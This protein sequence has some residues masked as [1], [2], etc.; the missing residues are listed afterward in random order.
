MLLGAF[1]AHAL[2]ETLSPE[3]LESYDTGIRYMMIHSLVLLFINGA[4]G[5]EKKSAETLSYL[6]LLGILLFTG[7]ILLIS[8]GLIEAASIW[9]VTPLGGLLL[10]AGWMGM[11]L[12]FFRRAKTRKQGK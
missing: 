5:L 4:S 10:I 1:G 2:K 9:F 11:A 6:F 7:S 8:T 3:A 12:A